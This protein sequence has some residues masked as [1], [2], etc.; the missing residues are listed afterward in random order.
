MM[1]LNK[2]TEDIIDAGVQLERCAIAASREKNC[3][4][5]D[6]DCVEKIC[7][8]SI[9]IMKLALKNDIK[10]L[11]KENKTEKNAE[12]RKFTNKM[13][14]KNKAILKMKKFPLSDFLF[15]RF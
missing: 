3:K 5:K 12:I 8:E 15:R 10:A 14:A 6:L 2:T 9:E 7:K 11:Q 13:I 4:R 1:K